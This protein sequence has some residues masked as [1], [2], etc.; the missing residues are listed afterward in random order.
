MNYFCLKQGEGL[1]NTAHTPL[2]KAPFCAPFPTPLQ[3]RSIKL[4]KK[5]IEEKR[6]C[7]VTITQYSSLPAILYEFIQH[8]YNKYSNTGYLFTS[9]LACYS[10][11]LNILYVGFLVKKKVLFDFNPFSAKCDQ[12]QHSTKI[13]K[14]HFV[15]Y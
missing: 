9:V 11:Q 10:G 4:T 5:E 2:P 6:D 8:F 7:Y 13:P 12:G 3:G 14:F 15:K 1:A